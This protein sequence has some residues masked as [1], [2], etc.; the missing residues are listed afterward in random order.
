MMAI[1][2]ITRMRDYVVFRDFTWPQDLPEFGRYNLLYGWNG[3][4]KTTLSRLFR[5]LEKQQNPT[6]GKLSVTI[7]DTDYS[8]EQFDMCSIPVRV[9]NRDFIAEAVFTTNGEVAP[10]FIIGERNVEKQK[11]VDKLKGQLDDEKDKR[12]KARA[13]LREAEGT[14]DR[15]CI[16][17][18]REIKNVL[19]SSP[20]N[21]YNNYNK[22][23]FRAK[24]DSFLKEESIDHYLLDD[25]AKDR[26]RKQHLATPKARLSEITYTF[27]DLK[28]LYEEVRGILSR[29]V[30][31]SVI[32]TLREDP[33]LAS[34]VRDGL[35]KHK[36]RKAQ[37]CL[38]CTQPLPPQRLKELEAHFSDEYER[39]IS[40]IDRKIHDIEN[41]I[42]GFDNLTLP[43]K[44]EFYD[45][46]SSDFIRA[47][48]AF[49]QVRGVVVSALQKLKGAL[50]QKKEAVFESS[51]F[52]E[53]IPEYD[54]NVLEVINAVIRKHNTTCD[55]FSARVS[56]AR[57]ELENDAVASSL[58]EYRKLMEAV[59]TAQEKAR[60]AES[61]VSS[62]EEKIGALERE[63]IEHQE[64]AERL[65]ED[66]QKYLGHSELRLEVE[67]TGYRITRAGEIASGLSEGERT[68]IAL[69]YFL[70]SLE[71]RSFDLDQGVVVLDDPVSSLDANALFS[72]FGFI[73]ERTQN[74]G[75][76]FIL[77]HNFTFFRQVRNWFHHLKGQNK[78][79]VNLR[80]ARFFMLDCAIEQDGR[81]TKLQWLDPLLE[82]YESEYHYLFAYIYRTA[83]GSRQTELQQNYVLPN[84]ARRLLEAF[85]AFRQ[86]QKAGELWQKVKSLNFDE[87]KK[88]RILRFLHTHSHH[89]EIG[90][91]EHDLSVLSEAQA[92]L[93][94]LLN[95]MRSEDEEHFLAMVSLVTAGNQNENETN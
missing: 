92:V 23:D 83:M 47:S 31:S 71:D 36:D 73:R 78:K 33:A 32:A 55:E 13:K 16:D 64:P 95:L 38:F 24:A 10:I 25:V 51:D 66:L 56:K 94:D 76:L 7:G 6:K 27:P 46:L 22:G 85:L 41:R 88:V 2:K 43:N 18:A 65:N 5:H 17:R 54:S 11:E 91:P 12:D 50:S 28:R 53:E 68:A 84:I 90:E 60:K 52:T 69:L 14:L 45:D 35:S 42:R 59:A 44:A 20:A 93:K 37:T 63:I 1:R 19:S 70:R 4:G 80:P 72:A 29:T 57:E 8:E 77:T 62:L 3:T 87:C 86:P 82:E 67:E 15:F 79:D 21:R 89:G 34:W 9:F 81:C 48:D 30:V 58:D 40:E 75:Q 61:S 39:F 74:A 49:N 26:L